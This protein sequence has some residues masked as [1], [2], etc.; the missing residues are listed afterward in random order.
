MLARGIARV[1]PHGDRAGGGMRRE[2]LPQP[3]LL[4]RSRV[5]AADLRAVAVDH[6]QVPLAEVVA[7]VALRGIAGRRAEVVE[8]AAGVRRA[9][10]VVADDRARARLEAA[11][12]RAVA[13]GELPGRAVFVGVVAEREDRPVDVLEQVRGLGGGTE[14]LAVGDV[15]GPDDD[16]VRGGRLLRAQ[17]GRGAERQDAQR[18]G[19]RSFHRRHYASA[20]RAPYA[21][22]RRSGQASQ[23][24][25][26]ALHNSWPCRRSSWCAAMS[27]S[28]SS[29]HCGRAASRTDRYDAA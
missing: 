19:E 2:V 8:V 17:D 11:P 12:G 10:L 21:H 16:G 22:S 1:V 14:R 4:G 24:G 7:V 6:D 29:F 15:A 25:W 18:R 13:V 20:A 28:K 9:V 5:A 3:L 26:D 23:R 27:Q